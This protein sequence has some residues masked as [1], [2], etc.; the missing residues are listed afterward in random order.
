MSLP[1]PKIY[2]PHL[3]YDIVIFGYAARKL[4]ILLLEY[5]NTGWMALPGGFIKRD[6]DLDLAVKNGLYERTGLKDIYLEQFHTFGEMKRFQ[7]KTMKSILFASGHAVSDDFW[8]LDRFLSIGHYSLIPFDAVDPKPDAISDAIGWYD[9]DAL[10][11]LIL[12]HS[13][14]VNKALATLRRDLNLKL[15][16]C[17]LLPKKFTMKEL[18]E[19]YEAVLNQQLH[20]VSFQ[21]KMLASGVLERIGKRFSGKSHKAP[22]LYKFTDQNLV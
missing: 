14:I 10:P 19:V 5:Q 2:L 7:P 13:L 3:A 11:E 4:K 1:D 18:Q 16:G 20:R 9:I 22:Y 17:N 15:S 12:D 6:E 8:M 21:R